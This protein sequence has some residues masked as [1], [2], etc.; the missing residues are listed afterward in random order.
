MWTKM[1]PQ[2]MR[3]KP[4]IIMQLVAETPD[5]GYNTVLEYLR[6]YYDPYNSDR[7]W[8]LK[9][10]ARRGSSATSW[11]NEVYEGDTLC[12]RV[13]VQHLGSSVDA[14]PPPA[15]TTQKYGI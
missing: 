4:G 15:K 2:A 5:R 12:A 3:D 11:R 7:G 8:A 14:N 13:R 10:T 1:P 9:E 6:E